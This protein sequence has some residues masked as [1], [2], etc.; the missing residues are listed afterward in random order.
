V[1]E[2]LGETFDGETD[3][4]GNRVLVYAIDRATWEMPVP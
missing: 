3:L 1:A 2:R 4:L